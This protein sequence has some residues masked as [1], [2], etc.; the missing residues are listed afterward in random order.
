MHLLHE[1]ASA[2]VKGAI[3]LLPLRQS[4]EASI[5]GHSR[6]LCA[7]VLRVQSYI[8]KMLSIDAALLMN[9]DGKD[10]NP[11]PRSTFGGR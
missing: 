3:A 2:S 8:S 6:S 4:Q 10:A 11:S 7:Q 5:Q 9:A 1:H